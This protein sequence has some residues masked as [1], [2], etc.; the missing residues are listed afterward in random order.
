MSFVHLHVHSEYSLLDGLSRIPALVR[1]AKE[2]GMPAVALTDHGALFGAI[3]FYNAAKAEGIKPI[4]GIETYLA[5]RG[6]R[7]RDPQL[8][9]KSFH[10]LLLAENQT[11]YKN[12]LKIA[13][14][15]QL[16]GFYYRPRIDRAYLERHN[17][18]LIT[19]TGCLSGEIPKALAQ[20]QEDKAR[21]LADW[22]ME[23]FGRE[24][25]FFELQHHHVPELEQVNRALIELAKRY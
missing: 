15:S 13:T 2:M 20:G 5:A 9:S 11:G 8:D 14:A 25:F 18:G 23:V 3:E 7:D 16:E 12:L 6:M 22:Y 19:T 17:A 4:I 10:L 21:Q 24:R 1:R